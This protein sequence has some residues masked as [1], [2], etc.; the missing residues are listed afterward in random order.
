MVKIIINPYFKK[1][2]NID[3]EQLNLSLEGSITVKELLHKIGINKPEYT[4]IIV[5]GK[6]SAKTSLVKEGDVIEILPVFEGG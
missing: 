4:L 1:L 6:A 2:F 3:Q 5:N